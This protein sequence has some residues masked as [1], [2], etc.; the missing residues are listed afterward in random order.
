MAAG[1]FCLLLGFAAAGCKKSSA[2]AGV[3]PKVFDSA[4]PELKEAWTMALSAAQTNGYATAYLT[5]RRMQGQPGL[6][7]AQNRAI[8]AESTLV[9]NRMTEAAR[10][11]DAEAVKA[12]QEI[13]AASRTG[14]R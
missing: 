4:P 7:E 12:M 14:G 10:N 13:R 8:A 11:G 3:D 9:N 6:N 1:S 5:L 2:A